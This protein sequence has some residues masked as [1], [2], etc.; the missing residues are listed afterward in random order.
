VKACALE[1]VNENR[2]RIN[3]GLDQ[4]VPQK[5]LLHGVELDGK[6]VKGWE[7][8]RLNFSKIHEL[9]WKKEFSGTIPSFYRAIFAVDSIGD[10]FMNAKG[11]GKGVACINGFNIGMYW[12]SERPQLTLYVPSWL[13]KKG[14]NEV[15]MLNIIC[16]NRITRTQWGKF[17]LM[18]FRKLAFDR[19]PKIKNLVLEPCL[20]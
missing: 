11:F 12:A 20:L 2:A 4:E 7:S 13:L 14:R 6:K 3:Y 5:G 17:R 18:T 9:Q 19:G 1:I 10:T 15:I 16:L 8:I